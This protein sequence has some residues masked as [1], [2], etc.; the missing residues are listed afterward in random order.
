MNCLICGD[1]DSRVNL[2]QNIYRRPPS[3]K[4]GLLP[5]WLFSETRQQL[6]SVIDEF[7]VYVESLDVILE[8][9]FG[10]TPY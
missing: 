8:P 1:S 2:R 7:R 6:T 4:E 9:G 3:E 5:G 10:N